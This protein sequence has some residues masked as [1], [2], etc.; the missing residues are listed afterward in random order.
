MALRMRKFLGEALPQLAF[1]PVPVRLRAY[2][3]DA[4]ALDTRRGVLI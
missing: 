3:G 4:V 1:E 2:V